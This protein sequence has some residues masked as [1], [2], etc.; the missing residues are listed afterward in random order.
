LPEDPREFRLAI[1]RYV[2]KVYDP[3]ARTIHAH[4][5]RDTPGRAEFIRRLG[6]AGL[7]GLSWPKE[8]GG[9]S[10][11]AVHQAILQEELEYADQPTPSIEVNMIGPTLIRIGSPSLKARYLLPIATG[12]LVLALGY[13]EP[14]AG[15][16]LASMRTKAVLDGDAFVINGRKMFTSNAD[17]AH[18]IW[19]AAR[20]SDEGRRHEG[21]SIILVDTELPG[22]EIRPV[23]T[24]GG[25]NT[26]E[27]TFTDVRVPSD[28]LVG[29]L[30]RG[31]SYMMEALDHERMAGL[32][33]GGLRRDLEA[34]AAGVFGYE[35]SSTQREQL[36]IDATVE[37]AAVRTHFERALGRLERGEVPSSE[38]TM[39][40]LRASEVRQWLSDRVIDEFGP[41]SLLKGEEPSSL[42]HGRFEYLS[43]AEVVSTIVAGT[44]E[45]QRNILANRHL[46]LPRG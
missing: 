9:R 39:L 33:C 2:R 19:L 37:V 41:E 34:L 7:L 27:V 29:E 8:Y 30:N 23:L 13:S 4:G 45:I 1:R 35:K 11:S 44:S 21:I 46:G 10:L 28:R 42:L 12:E 36:V 22:V 16:D 31:W 25:H 24:M 3:D 32:S 38:A 14:D 20:T 26:T 40:K 17:Y 6:D 15:S 43:R 18:A 5:R